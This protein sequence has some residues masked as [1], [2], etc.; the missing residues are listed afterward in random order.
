MPIIWLT[1]CFVACALT[2]ISALAFVTNLYRC[3]KFLLFSSNMELTVD[4]QKLFGVT[5]FGWSYVAVVMSIKMEI[6]VVKIDLVKYVVSH[7][8]I[9]VILFGCTF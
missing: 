3:F 6:P 1:W 8:N 5:D 7:V 2:I 4:Q 9:I